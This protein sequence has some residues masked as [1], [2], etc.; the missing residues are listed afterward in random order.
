MKDVQAV[1]ARSDA[2]G[3]SLRWAALCVAA[4]GA[5]PV[6]AQLGEATPEE[7]KIGR[8]SPNTPITDSTPP[9]TDPRDFSGQ[10]RNPPRAAAGASGAAAG[11]AGGAQGPGANN[12]G[13]ERTG[14]PYRASSRYCIPGTMVLS[15]GEAG[16]LIVQTPDELRVLTEEHHNNRR[17]Y[18]GQKHTQPLVRSVN[19]DSIAHWEGNTLVV[20]TIGFIGYGISPTLVRNERISKSADGRTLNDD[21]SYQDASG[22]KTPGSSQTRLVWAPGTRVLEY[23][24]E[25]GSDAYMSKD[26]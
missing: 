4:L 6:F 19:G 20:E 23:I 5:A 3:R 21:V 8:P 7:A 11:A 12:G 10:W 14:N 26:Y 13:S 22:R 15:G 16:T 24:C 25:D 17:I 9:P 18:I 2:P 1:M